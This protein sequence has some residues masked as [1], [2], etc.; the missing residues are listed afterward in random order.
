VSGASWPCTMPGIHQTWHKYNTKAGVSIS[1]LFSL[2]PSFHNV[3]RQSFILQA[4]E[5]RACR[6]IVRRHWPRSV[7][8]RS[9]CACRLLFA[10]PLPRA[11]SQCLPFMP[12]RYRSRE[13]RKDT[14]SFL[15]LSSAGGF[16]AEYLLLFRFILSDY[17]DLQRP[18]GSFQLFKYSAL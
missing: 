2:S 6:L 10:R 7:S 5:Y 8:S 15:P 4:G 9:I 11:I 13:I 17:S 14:N 18:A 16:I 1:L 3:P 12:R